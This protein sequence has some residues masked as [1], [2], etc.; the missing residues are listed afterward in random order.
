[1]KYEGRKAIVCLVGENLRDTP[2]IAALVF[3]ELADKKIRMI[4]QGASE[5]NL[6]FVIEEDE[7]PD[8]I[9]RLHKTFFSELDPAVFAEN[10]T[11]MTFALRDRQYRM[12]LL[13]LGRGK[14]GSLVAEVAACAQAQSSCSRSRGK[15]RLRRAHSGKASRHR[16]RDRLHTPHC[17]IANIEACVKAGKNMVVGT[18]GWYKEAD[19]IRE[20]VEQSGSG[21]LYGANFSVG[22]NLFFDI[23]RTAPPPFA[24]TTPDR[25]SSA[26]TRTRK[27]RPRARRS[28]SRI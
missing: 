13:I 20:L 10:E 11:R 8:V 1:M 19:R 15:R 23:A 22:V 21:F 5:I 27:T 26:I 3:R 24:T 16:W 2:G 4:S 25:S 9:Q 6:T 7:V 12:N 14:T 18:T 17:V 28:R